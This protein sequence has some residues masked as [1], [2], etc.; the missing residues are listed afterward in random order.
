MER[1]K[2]LQELEASEE[3]ITTDE[4][5]EHRLESVD[6][7]IKKWE[8][9]RTVLEMCVSLDLVIDTVAAVDHAWGL[10]L[11]VTVTERGRRSDA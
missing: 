11:K 10:S 8:Q 4:T 1:N 2:I 7:N 5:M 9:M 6:E 3:L